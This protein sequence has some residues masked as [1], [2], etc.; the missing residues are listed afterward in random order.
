MK[1][2]GRLTGI[3]VFVALLLG[4]IYLSL[5]S[6]TEIKNS[7][8]KI[9]L[10]GNYFLSKQEYFNFARLNKISDY[11]FLTLPIIKSRLEKHPYVLKA[12]VRFKGENTVI[13]NITEKKFEAILLNESEQYLLSDNFLVIPV[14][15]YTKNIDLPVI[16][17]LR[18]DK[19][20]RGFD[21]LKNDDS[22]AAF[23]IIE[24]AKLV[25]M[26]MYSNISDIDL[27]NGKDIILRLKGYDFQ[28][29]LGRGNEAAKVVYFDRIW[30]K[31]NSIN[32][33]VNGFISYVDLRFDKLIYLGMV[34][35]D[36]EVK[37][38]QG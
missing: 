19:K 24:S 35:L 34:N 16:S 20:V 12:D 38:G 11:K 22:K 6:N 4:V 33:P 27:R 3:L 13:I 2:K 14:L 25:N 29:I 37:G 36:S 7:V 1:N 28:V 15:P 31:I 17:N 8:E 9:E 5:F 23:R 18:L 26:N 30:N 10:S 21:I 32:Q